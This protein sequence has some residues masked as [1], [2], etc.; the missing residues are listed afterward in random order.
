MAINDP[1]NG[2][3]IVAIAGSNGNKANTS[4]SAFT[5]SVTGLQAGQ[6]AIACTV[7]VSKGDN[8][9]TSL[10]STGTSLTVVGSL[11]TATFTPTPFDTPTPVESP[12]PTSLTPVDTATPTSSTPVDTATPTSLTP[13]DTATPTSLTPVDTATPTSLTPLTLPH[14]RLQRRLTLQL[15]L[16]Q[17]RSILPHL[18]NHPL[19]RLCRMAPSL[20]K[21][22]LANRSRWACTQALLW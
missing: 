12:T 13:V 1:Q 21:C 4:G 19:P 14:L 5:F 2:S 8:A 10:A 9:L 16:H 3:F 15:Q 22:W 18:W 17:H 6:S 11:P 20:D 7:R